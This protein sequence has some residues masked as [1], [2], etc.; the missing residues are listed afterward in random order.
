MDYSSSL[1][2]LLPARRVLSEEVLNCLHIK[3][4]LDLASVINIWDALKTSMITA[5]QNA[6]ICNKASDSKIQN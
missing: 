4:L 6:F 2:K 1:S 5:R 3:S